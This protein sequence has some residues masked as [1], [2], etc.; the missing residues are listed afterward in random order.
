MTTGLTVRSE[1]NLNKLKAMLQKIEIIGNLVADAELKQGKDGKEFISFRV[2]VSEGS[3][4]D[5]RS[6]YYDVN[7]VKSGIL[8]YLRKG[9][10]VYVSGRLSLSAVCKDE[11]AFINAYISAKD[12]VLCGGSK[13]D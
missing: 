9:Q 8:Q 3:G 6:T 7:Y 4:E 5:R 10:P 12:I 1:T 2:A 11:R 13:A